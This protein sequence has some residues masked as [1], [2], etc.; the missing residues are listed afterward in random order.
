[1]R[2]LWALRFRGLSLISRRDVLFA[3]AMLATLAGAAGPL[4]EAFSPRDFFWDWRTDCDRALI[5]QG[6]EGHPRVGDTLGWWTGTWVGQ[7]PFWRPLT[8][9]CF[10]LEWKVFGWE[11]QEAWMLIH[12][13]SRLLAA[14][15]LFVFAEVIAGP[16]LALFTAVLFSHADPLVSYWRLWSTSGLC[17]PW[18][19]KD[20]PDVWLMTTATAALLC[21]WKGA[22]WLAVVFA[23]ISACF[24]ETGFVTFPAVA[25]IAYLRH[26]KHCWRWVAAALVL[27][28]AMVLVKMTTVGAG[29]I[30]GSNHSW[31]TRAW[32]A[33]APYPLRMLLGSFSG[34]AI[35]ATGFALLLARP[36]RTVA[37]AALA[38]LPV[39]LGV[40]LLILKHYA[41]DPVSLH[42]A[43]FVFFDNL[44]GPVTPTTALWVYGVVRGFAP[45]V[46]LAAALFTAFACPAVIAPQ[47]QVHAFYTAYAFGA[48]AT[49]LVWGNVLARSSKVS[50]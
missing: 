40:Q 9:L 2:G 36:S 27:A 11:N 26:G 4:R 1:M 42:T 16:I 3:F 49:A 24:K 29:Y 12:V 37:V 50:R 6:L 15:V 47:T 5:H 20:D 21:A 32:Y 18:S 31:P 19:W 7:V 33:L 39:A 10:W 22:G 14:A 13:V 28:T 43:A 41:A 30:M 25:A 35:V 38:L 34:Q 45:S 8:S 17:A 44:A 48:L 46:V 23:A